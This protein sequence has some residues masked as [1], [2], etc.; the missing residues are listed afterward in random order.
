MISTHK[1]KRQSSSSLSNDIDSS[2]ENELPEKKTKPPKLL[3]LDHHH[4]I[5]KKCQMSNVCCVEIINVTEIY[6]YGVFCYHPDN[7]DDEKIYLLENEPKS[8]R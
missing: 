2:G 4:I 7:D 3:F 1:L 5:T 6:Q 8:S